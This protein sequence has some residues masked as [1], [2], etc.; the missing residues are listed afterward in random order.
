MCLHTV[1]I[2]IN[3]DLG[4]QWDFQRTVYIARFSPETVPIQS[5]SPGLHVGECLS[6]VRPR[7]K[8]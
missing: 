6:A 3:E 7:T 5:C 1:Q 4:P 2:L 8:L